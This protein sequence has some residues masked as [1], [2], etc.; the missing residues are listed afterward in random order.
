MADLLSK[1]ISSN[2]M[3]AI[4]AVIIYVLGAITTPFLKEA[5]K[6]LYSHAKQRFNRSASRVVSNIPE[7]TEAAPADE[8][9]LQSVAA[10]SPNEMP[11]TFPQ[12]LKRIAS[13]SFA[14]VRDAYDK[15]PPYQRASVSQHYAGQRVRW[16]TTFSNISDTGDKL[17]LYMRGSDRFGS[18]VWGKVSLSEYPE[19]K[20][21]HSGHPLKVTGTIRQVSD[22]S[23]DLS[24]MDV[25]IID[26]S[27]VDLEKWLDG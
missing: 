27:K 20:T 12:A 24:D 18:S 8:T 21:M 14:E 22:L 10:P 2:W 25:E 1:L 11:A 19:L 3:L 6:D 23:I 5:G 13:T 16:N 26:K 4:A 9:V 7:K 15:A 17:T